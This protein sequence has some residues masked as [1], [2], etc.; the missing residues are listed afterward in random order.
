MA[1]Q[2]IS[3]ELRAARRWV[4][5]RPAEGLFLRAADEIDRLRALV[6]QGTDEEA[7]LRVKPS[8]GLVQRMSESYESFCAAT[9]GDGWVRCSERLPEPGAL[10]LIAFRDIRPPHTAHYGLAVAPWPEWSSTDAWMA[11]PPLPPP[12]S[13]EGAT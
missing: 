4:D 11:I 6:L 10:V 7:R 12:P 13:E 9:A 5:S 3:A 8:R 1:D 2:D